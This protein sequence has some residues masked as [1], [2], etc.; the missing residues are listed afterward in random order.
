MNPNINCSH[1]PL[2]SISEQYKN[3]GDTLLKF[4]LEE[5]IKMKKHLEEKTD[6]QI[7]PTLDV[8]V[9]AQPTRKCHEHKQEQ[10]LI[11]VKGKPENIDL[12][13]KVAASLTKEDPKHLTEIFGNGSGFFKN[14][15]N[16]DEAES[17][18]AAVEAVGAE[19]ELK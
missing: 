4:T 18:V 3:V 16:K 14:K 8:R 15:V 7:M 13:V 12:A 11:V 19:V 6:I 17:L 10:V 5:L 2:G 9:L 1:I